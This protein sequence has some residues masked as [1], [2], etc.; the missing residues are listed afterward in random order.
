[1]KGAE[2]TA[3]FFPWDHTLPYTFVNLLMHCEDWVD[4]Y[5]V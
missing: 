1:M 4:F 3:I 2:D 5:L